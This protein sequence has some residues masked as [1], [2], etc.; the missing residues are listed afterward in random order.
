MDLL[1]WLS[2]A[3]MILVLVSATIGR[4]NGGWLWSLLGASLTALFGLFGLA[5]VLQ[6]SG[7]ARTTYRQSLIS[8]SEQG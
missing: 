2:C 6:F 3:Q 1:G 8:G 7:A 4:R 5:I